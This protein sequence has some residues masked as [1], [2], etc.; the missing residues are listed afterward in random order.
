MKTY[1]VYREVE[2]S[3]DVEADSEEE[4]VEKSRLTH[5]MDWEANVLNYYAIAMREDD[6]EEEEY[7]HAH[8]GV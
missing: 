8:E 1:R 5:F 2:E 6:E 4:A 7:H 3:L